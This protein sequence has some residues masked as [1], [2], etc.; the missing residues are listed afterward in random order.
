MIVLLGF[1]L[2]ALVTLFAGS[3]GARDCS[4]GDDDSKAGGAS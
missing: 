3:I 1:W 2:G 4:G